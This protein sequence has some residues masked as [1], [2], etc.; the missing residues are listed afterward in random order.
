MSI[1]LAGAVLIGL[2]A[3]RLGIPLPS[4]DAIR[5][6]F[7]RWQADP[8]VGP[9]LVPAYLAF[10]FVFGCM[11]FPRGPVA[12][13]GIGLMGAWKT[14]LAYCAI[15]PVSALIQ[16]LVVRW[17]I[18][19]WVR[20]RLPE[21]ARKMEDIILRRGFW[22]VAGIRGF[23]PTGMGVFN[24]VCAVS[25]LRPGTFFAGSVAGYAIS[26]VA[27]VLLADLLVDLYTRIWD[28]EWALPVIAAM[29]ILFAGAMFTLYG[30]LKR[31]K[32][33][34]SGSER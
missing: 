7:Q 5:E 14:Y 18:T 3:W 30:Q 13:V 2:A 15:L 21:D 22:A 12:A 9:N 31:Q 28:S 34:G 20:E 11:G 17:A 24:A 4:P 29:F 10:I 23:P 1:L 16:F 32:P 26:S 27:Y 19:D 6:T 8:K 25:A 33:G